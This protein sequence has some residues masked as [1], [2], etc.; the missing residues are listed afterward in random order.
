MRTPWEAIDLGILMT[1]AWWFTLFAVWAIPASVVFLAATFLLSDY[2]WAAY[3]VVWWFKPL[4]DRGPL[5]VASRRLFGEHVSLREALRAL[6][7]LYKTDVIPWLTYRRFSVSRA[8]DMPLTVLEKAKG[9]ARAKRIS[10]LHRKYGAVAGW[11]TTLLIHME[12]LIV[13]GVMSFLVLM[14]PEYVEIDYLDLAVESDSIALWLNHFISFA[15]MTLVGPFYAVCGFALYICRRIDLE[16]WDIEI[17]FRHLLSSQTVRARDN[18]A[19]KAL[20][21]LF[22]MVLLFGSSVAGAPPA[23]AEPA[24]NE[25][26]VLT[27]PEEPALA[28]DKQAI[29]EIL[30]RD[31]FHQYE[32]VTDWRFKKVDQSN[33]EIPEWM[34][35]I[36]ERLVAL[37]AGMEFED[38]SFNYVLLVEIVIWLLFF[39]LVAYILYRYRKGIRRLVFSGR[40]PVPAV[41]PPE[42]LFGLDVRQESLPTDVVASVEAL[43]QNGRHRESISLFYRALLGTLIHRHNCQFEDSYT[44]GECITVVRATGNLPL[45]E[46]TES[47]SGMWQRLAYGHQQPS[48]A[49]FHEH[50]RR[51]REIFSDV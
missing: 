13:L 31:A 24:A 26:L 11:L 28:A 17:H 44:E 48:T 45:T 4:F 5:Y 1:R 39:L 42:T 30:E 23:M 3:I 38:G 34:I 9:A 32:T 16:A 19:G 35:Y 20:A 2:I 47:L 29:I 15:A 8:F 6:P 14:V 27:L 50:C 43:W 41:R 10:V 25:P 51:W 36:I 49:D 22:A 7:G 18:S 33:D 46:F 12:M 37:F 21:G 40:E